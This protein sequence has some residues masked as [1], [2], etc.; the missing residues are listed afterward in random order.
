MN[1]G[2]FARCF[3]LFSSIFA[4]PESDECLRCVR[5]IKLFVYSHLCPGAGLE[6]CGTRLWP[7]VRHK[8]ECMT[9]E[10]SPEIREVAQGC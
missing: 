10:D 4:L 7:K 3:M 1:L 8:V 2:G 6:F 5:K 9:G